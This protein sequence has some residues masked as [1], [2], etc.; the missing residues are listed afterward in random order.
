MVLW[1]QNREGAKTS[2]D[3]EQYIEDLLQK[4]GKTNCKPLKTPI[5]PNEK[6]V[7]ATDDDEIADE[8]TY[9]SLIGSLLF[10]AKQVRPVILCGV[11]VLSWFMEK[12]TKTHMNA[13]KRILRYLRGSWNLKKDYC[14]QNNPI[15]PGESDA[16][17]SG[18]QNDRKSTTGLYFKYSQ[19]SGAI[20][21]QVRK[22]QSV[23]L[24][25]C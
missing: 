1:H 4:Q 8:R 15:F 17:W 10:L 13:V 20:S 7:K 19:D 2:L 14:K 25:S 9:R 16:D 5:S 22:Q 11:N 21:W 6:F 23:A 18:D 3:Q 12:P 24:S